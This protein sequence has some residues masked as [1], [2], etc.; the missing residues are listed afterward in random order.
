MLVFSLV[1]QGAFDPDRR[2]VTI[3][4]F[5]SDFKGKSIQVLWPDTGSWYNCEVRKVNVK[6]KTASLWYVDS[7]EL[8]DINLYEAILNMEVSWPKEDSPVATSPAKKGKRKA[9]EPEESSESESDSDDDVPLASLKP[10][11]RAPA[12]ARKNPA[13]KKKPKKTTGSTARTADDPRSGVRENVFIKFLEAMKTAQGE[14]SSGQSR[15][16]SEL[17]AIA[18]EVETQLYVVIDPREYNAKARTLV[19]N[20]KDPKNPGLRANVLT[21]DL[22]A[23]RLVRMSPTELANKDLQAMRAEREAKIGEDAFLPELPAEARVRKTHKGEEVMFDAKELLEE[24]QVAGDGLGHRETP[25][26]VASDSYHTAGNENSDEDEAP[27]EIPDEGTTPRAPSAEP[28]TPPGR[29]G[30][31]DELAEGS[32]GGMLTSFEQFAAGHDDSGGDDDEP[33]GAP[34]S[35]PPDAG[36]HPT[37]E[38][39]EYDPTKGFDDDEDDVP[40]ASPPQREPSPVPEPAPA[41]SEPPAARRKKEPEAGEWSGTVRCQGLRDCV[42]RAVP[43]GGE[44]ADF[45]PL[46]P[47]SLEI[48]GR[49]AFDATH[50]FIRQVVDKSRTRAVTAAV[51]GP[52]PNADNSA[53]NDKAVA[54]LASQYG[55]RERCGVAEPITGVLEVY[56]IPRG[57]LA[58]KLMSTLARKSKAK[59]R[60]KGDMLMVAVHKR[61]IGPDA[62]PLP[63]EQPQVQHA[64]DLLPAPPGSGGRG[65]P[66]PSAS[67]ARDD[68]PGAGDIQDLLN[69]V[70]SQFGGSAPPAGMPPPLAPPPPIGGGLDVLSGPFPDGPPPPIGGYPPSGR[71]GPLFD[72]NRGPPPMDYPPRP[73]QYGA[74]PPHG[75]GN[76]NG[77]GGPPPPGGGYQNGP[78]MYRG[79]RS[80]PRRSPPGGYGGRSPPRDRGGYGGAPPPRYNDRGRSPPRGG[81]GGYGGPPP[82]GQWGGPPRGG[83]G[84][85]GGPGPGPPQGHGFRGGPPPPQEYRDNRGGGYGGGGEDQRQVPPPPPGRY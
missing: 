41:A 84:G 44:R 85:G 19:F 25:S 10:S 34:P 14:A 45:G 6:A 31:G 46:F 49:V 28:G 62:K 69:Q 64:S 61:G 23:A 51:C 73:H 13:E 54:A 56:F 1:A 12:P 38:D 53:F 22:P 72:G 2:L 59:L 70:N 35:P 80:P 63:A 58:D 3:G 55:K 50:R 76:N 11:K 83:Y 9:Q 67:A 39:A 42:V 30:S 79:S 15:D 32:G 75:Y 68:R 16:E 29:D 17:A 8:E 33:A 40:G 65:T 71:G 81:P 18:M 21:G 27:A 60:G 36:A 7:E 43:I 20:L 78:G 57:K 37:D 26:L 77:N 47:T 66:P 48:K 82:G 5:N 52:D 74:P 24:E 4:E